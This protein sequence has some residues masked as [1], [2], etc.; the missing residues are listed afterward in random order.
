L[1]TDRWRSRHSRGYHD[2]K[3]NLIGL[4]FTGFPALVCF[5]SLALA[6]GTNTRTYPRIEVF[7]GYSSL[8]TNDHTFQFADIGPV[9]H[10][11]FDEGGRGFET[12]VI[13]NLSRWVGVVGDFSAYFSTNQFPVQAVTTCSQLPCPT[14]T[15]LGSINPRLF[16]FLGG[17]EIK[18]RNHSR[19]A[20]FFH[21]LIGAAHSSATFSTTGSALNL[22]RTDA[23]TGF[24]M[25]CGGGL[26]VRITRRF[27]FR[28]LV[29]YSQAFVGSNALPR[30]RVDALA[31]S[32]GLLFH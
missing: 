14:S 1:G 28:T 15:Q 2:T 31:W 29:M 13:G 3:P 22:S 25:R 5:A 6:Q 19:L 8:E 21:T 32:S 4:E 17:P 11:D 7:G 27:S 12:A 16:N 9:S 10:L 24:A 26:D 30:Q 20:P 23:E 18:W